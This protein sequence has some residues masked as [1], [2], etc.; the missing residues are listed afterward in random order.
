LEHNSQLD[1]QNPDSGSHSLSLAVAGACDGDNEK[2]AVSNSLSHDLALT[3]T[4]GHTCK[5][6][7]AVGFEPNANDKNM[8][9]KRINC[10]LNTQLDTQNFPADLQEII[11]AWSKLD[12]AL[13]TAV[14][15]VVR[16]YYNAK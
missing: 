8:A 3:G 10:K 11:N 15:A 2:S 16:S 1:T 5:K 12:D 4:D 13:K 7:G 6:V 9:R 14:L